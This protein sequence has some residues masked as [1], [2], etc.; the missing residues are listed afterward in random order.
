MSWSPTRR[1]SIVLVTLMSVALAVLIADSGQGVSAAEDDTPTAAGVVVR[2]ESMSL[3]GADAARNARDIGFGWVLVEGD[4]DSQTADALGASV[5]ANT[6]YELLDDPLFPDQWGFK[7]TGQSG[8]TPGADIDAEAAWAF[9]EGDAGQIVAVLDSGIDLDHPDLVD[10]LWT[11]TAEIPGNGIDDDAN[12]YIDDVNGWDMADDDSDVQDDL[13]HGT[14]VASVIAGTRNSVGVVGLAPETT[15]MPVRV[16]NPACPLSSIMEG[17]NYAL[18]NGARIINLSLGSHTLNLGLADAIEAANDAGAVVVAAAGNAG[19]DNDITPLYPASFSTPNVI[20]VAATDRDDDLGVFSVGSSNVG[21]TSVDLAA[22]GVDIIMANID[23]WAENSGTSFSTA[24]VS[25]T[26]ALLRA[27]QPNASAIVIKAMI[28][29]SVDPLASLTGKMVTGGR[30]DAGEAL[31]KTL[32]PV[33]VA[34]GSPGLGW[35]PLEVDVSG[36]ASSSPGD[37]IL[38]WTW[39]SGPALAS[40]ETTA[41]VL[42]TVGTNTVTLTVADAY[43]GTDTDTFN[44]LVGE[45]FIDTRDSIFRLDIAWMSAKGITKGC[46]P[47]TNNRYCPDNGVTRGQMAAFIKRALKLPA[48]STDYFDDD[49]GSIFEDDINR[50]AAAGITKGCNPPVNDKFCP[51][52]TVT[53]QQMAAFIKRALKLPTTSTDYFDDDNGSIFE[54]D[55]NRIAEAGI[56]KGCNPPTNNKYCPSN[57]VK[58]GQMAAFVHRA[59]P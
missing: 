41:I 3:L 29:D 52:S 58:R 24:M 22:P 4:L 12:G 46:N 21:A 35:R 30:L 47:P 56:T 45:D 34:S 48:T 51:D 55:I 53:R 28:E 17:V 37:S 39:T 5:S 1:I 40:G 31:V 15:I 42:D 10:R 2:A 25:G 20:A 27:E 16:C 8:G 38:S 33:A 59:D 49:N 19:T 14:A 54:D 36:V 44:V 7:N 9:T 43:G 18:D 26:A 13:G 32:P 50:L 6:I 23:A 57:P 11:N